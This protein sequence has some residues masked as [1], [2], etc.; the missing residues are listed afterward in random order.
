MTFHLSFLDL[1]SIQQRNIQG[2]RSMAEV[3]VLC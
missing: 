3:P 2:M 1:K